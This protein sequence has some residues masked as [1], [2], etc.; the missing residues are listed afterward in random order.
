MQISEVKG[1]MYDDSAYHGP[2]LEPCP[3]FVKP[4][5]RNGASSPVVGDCDYN[6]D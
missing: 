2:S 5:F 1:R 4:K 6:Y 3:F